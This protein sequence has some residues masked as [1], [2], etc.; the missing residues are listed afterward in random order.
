MNVYVLH[1]ICYAYEIVSFKVGVFLFIGFEKVIYYM[2]LE[3]V[4]EVIPCFH[5][6]F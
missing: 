5:K 4:E 1:T 6:E 2:L 3:I